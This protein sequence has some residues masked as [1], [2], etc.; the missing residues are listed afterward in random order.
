MIPP[1]VHAAFALAL[2]ALFASSALHKW[3]I[4]A[5]FEALLAG[6]GLIPRALLPAVARVLPV[7]EALLAMALVVPSWRMPAGAGAAVLLAAYLVA[8]LVNLLRGRRDIDCGCSPSPRPLSAALALRNLLLVAAA[9]I[10]ALP[11][12]AGGAPAGAPF[13]AIGGAL[14]LA[15]AYL[16]V[17][18]GLSAAAARREWEHAED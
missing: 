10:V 14:A 17:E 13:A 8:I 3:R 6:Y 15:L 11:P 2:A 9:L 16:A 7:A 12:A 4:G 1:V 18:A 5:R